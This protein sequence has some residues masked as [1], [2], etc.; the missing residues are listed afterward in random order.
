MHSKDAPYRLEFRWGAF[1][2]LAADSLHE[3]DECDGQSDPAYDHGGPL[4]P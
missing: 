3:D 1:F 2:A 4:D